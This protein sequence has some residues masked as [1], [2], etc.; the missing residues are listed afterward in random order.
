MDKQI[1]IA[2]QNFWHI[3]TGIGQGSLVDATLAKD[4][5]GLPYVPGRQLKGLLR[6][7]VKTLQ[8]S[9]QFDTELDPELNIETLLF[10][11]RSQAEDT[12]EGKLARFETHAG[13]VQIGNGELAPEDQEAL[14]NQPQL[15]TALYPRLYQTAI[16][17]E[18]GTAERTS[19][20]GQEVCLPL[21][22]YAPISWNNRAQNPDIR[23]L[24]D[25][26]AS[27]E[28][29][30]FVLELACQMLPAIG[31]NRTRG[32]GEVVVTLLDKEKK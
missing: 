19:L 16:N 7:A 5:N 26:L 32:L 20:R 12:T 9:G 31:A 3:G 24:Q 23:K 8:L 4:S 27:H 25:Q 11:S 30:N 29:C 17:L 28:V 2:F 22:L 14:V 13:M 6:E 10:G 18:T 15:K 1:S 21:T